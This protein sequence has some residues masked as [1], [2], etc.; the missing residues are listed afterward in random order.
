MPGLQAGQIIG[1][2]RLLFPLG[3][4]GMGEVWACQQVGLQGFQKLIAL[5]VLKSKVSNENSKV[6]FLDEAK[7]AAAL[8]HPSIVPTIDLGDHNGMMFIAMDLV[9]G[10]SLRSLLQQCAKQ[11]ITVPPSIVAHVGLKMANALDY[12][13][14]RAELNG[15]KLQL[16]HRD[17][18]PHNILVDTSG[19]VR[20]MDF[21]VART[22]VQD[23]LSQVG[24]VRGKP[25]YMAPEQ[26]VGGTLTARTDVFALGTVMYEM[27][28]LRRLFGRGEPTK[29]MRAVLDH[30]PVPLSEALPEFP[31]SLSLVIE[32][33]LEKKPER[34]HADSGEL[35]RQL[36]EVLRNL[37]NS[38]AI[39]R[40][41]SQMIVQCFGEEAFEIDPHLLESTMAEIRLTPS[42]IGED[43]ELQT[44]VDK[45]APR[46]PDAA[47]YEAIATRVYWPSSETG[48][49]NVQPA[50]MN[51][52]YMRDSSVIV[53][54]TPSSKLPLILLL[55]A[56]VV[57][58]VL[59]LGV[60]KRNQE[61][62]LRSTQPVQQTSPSLKAV[63]GQRA[64]TEQ[65]DDINTVASPKVEKKKTESLKPTA[66][67]KDVQKPQ[68][69][70]QKNALKTTK[71]APPEALEN[72]AMAKPV[73]QKAATKQEVFR[74][75]KKL[76]AHNP[77]LA[78]RYRTT[79]IESGGKQ[80]K[81]Q[82][83][84]RK[85]KAALRK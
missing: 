47:F 3:K 69:K 29:S 14:S 37:P 26:V 71:R 72:K 64:K 82:S 38:T 73:Q 66:D 27:A 58:A 30:K 25:S 24:T 36:S 10:P 78:A 32:K 43:V 83:L 33:A 75:I 23:H 48:P 52:L 12:A 80:E 55:T 19:V 22:N 85:V 51:A 40:D 42:S 16:I 1:P 6:M 17:I 67:N 9:Q 44:R 2:Y 13:Y 62:N 79:L 84:R 68:Q 15:E 61:T 18:S 34:R 60:R 7:T 46:E 81:L 65:P 5:K 8:Q 31:K 4:G 56:F 63:T 35:Y 39:E 49:S 77:E 41:L 50:H 57:S 53:A 59:V 28:C 74:L 11:K 70:T 21:G 76:E 20:L 45:V 54:P